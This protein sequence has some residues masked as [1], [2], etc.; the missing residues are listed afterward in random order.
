MKKNEFKLGYSNTS[1]IFS[2]LASS[3]F[4]LFCSLQNTL[5]YKEFSKFF[6]SFSL[7][8]LLEQ[9]TTDSYQLPLNLCHHLILLLCDRNGYPWP[10]LATSP[11]CSFLLA[12]PQG[13]TPSPHRAT[14]CRFELITQILLGHVKG[15]IVV[16]HLWA[17]HY[18][19]SSTLHVWFI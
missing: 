19:Y 14:V 15:S 16:H 7:I 11:Y 12:G 17:R 18:F 3:D 10:F 6:N 8:R 1:I 4:Y 2:K 13:Y 9:L 5:K